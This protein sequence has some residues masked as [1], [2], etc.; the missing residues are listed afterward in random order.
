MSGLDYKCA[1]V[2]AP[3]QI[4]FQRVKPKLSRVWVQILH[5]RTNE[6]PKMSILEHFF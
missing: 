4:T 1:V 3:K 2:G 6:G 5:D